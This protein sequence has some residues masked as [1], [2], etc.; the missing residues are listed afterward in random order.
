MPISISGITAPG[1]T[2]ESLRALRAIMKEQAYVINGVFLIIRVSFLEQK[3]PILD[4]WQ[5]FLVNKEAKKNSKCHSWQEN[6]RL[7]KDTGRSWIVS[8][9][10]FADKSTS[11]NTFRLFFDRNPLKNGRKKPVQSSFLRKRHHK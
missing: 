1:G 11:K 4:I 2:V 10:F 6:G 8:C 3:A 7:W 9:S 5:P